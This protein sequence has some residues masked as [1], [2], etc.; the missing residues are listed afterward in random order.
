MKQSYWEL[1]AICFVGLGLASP[2]DANSDAVTPPPIGTAVKYSCSGSG[3]TKEEHRVLYNTGSLWGIQQSSTEAPKTKSAPSSSAEVS[4]IL[5][6]VSPWQYLIGIPSFEESGSSFR[7]AVPKEGD[8]ADLNTLQVGKSHAG[9][10]T[11]TDPSVSATPFE[12][13]VSV[14][15]IKE[16]KAKIMGLGQQKVVVLTVTTE[17]LNNDGKT[18]TSEVQ[19]S[20]IVKAVIARTTKEAD[21]VVRS[22]LADKMAFNQNQK[23]PSSAVQLTLA[24]QGSEYSYIC[25][26]DARI[27]EYT[28]NQPPSDGVVYTNV[29]YDHERHGRRVG[30]PWMHYAFVAEEFQPGEP[31]P[32]VETV[33]GFESLKQPQKPG[34][35]VG[36][37]TITKK[38]AA[39]KA[40]QAKVTVFDPIKMKSPYKDAEDVNEVRA[41][42][43]SGSDYIISRSFFMKRYQVPYMFEVNT[44]GKVTR[45][46]WLTSF[47]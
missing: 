20:P 35:Y 10:F 33:G 15:V 39:P 40:W 38:G 6:D 2:A 24:P 29:V 23:V 34:S 12:A 45:S 21:K 31:F 17:N 36:G 43:F 18:L 22:C 11:I 19:Y 28:V 7:M 16:E 46:C 5:T 47:R 26:G 37:V 9:V 44:S 41:T 4:P 3:P 42:R 30:E 32:T 14:A 8:L 25:T 1:L 13:K 27:I